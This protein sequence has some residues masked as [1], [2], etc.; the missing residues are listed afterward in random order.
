M[1]GLRE[2]LQRK[3]SSALAASLERKARPEGNR[4]GR[5]RVGERSTSEGHAQKLCI[6]FFEGEH[7]LQQ[8]VGGL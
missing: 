7:F 4:G 8:T 5:N 1:I 6:H 2:G 3:A